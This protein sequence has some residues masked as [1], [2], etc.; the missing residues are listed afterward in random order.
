MKRTVYARQVPGVEHVSLQDAYELATPGK[1]ISSVI[2]D[3]MLCEL[4]PRGRVQCG[5]LDLRRTC[6]L[7]FQADNG[8]NGTNYQ[9]N[10]NLC[11]NYRT[12]LEQGR[13]LVLPYNAPTNTHWMC[14][15]VWKDNATDIYYMQA[16]NSMRSMRQLYDGDCLKDASTFLRGVY[17]FVGSQSLPVWKVVR[18]RDCTEQ[19]SRRKTCALH[20]AANTYLVSIGRQFTHTF[21]ENFVESLRRFMLYK[22]SCLQNHNHVNKCNI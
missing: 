13:C 14:I 8:T 11:Q 19:Y 21:D 7:L 20:T 22:L 18:S 6:D 3:F 2:L 10:L 16:R 17:N 9:H 4:Y 1:Y 5:Y 15:L 12:W